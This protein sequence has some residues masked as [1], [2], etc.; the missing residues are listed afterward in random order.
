LANNRG[1]FLH[2]ILSSPCFA[3]GS[4]GREGL[5]ASVSEET[6]TRAWWPIEEILAPEQ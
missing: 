6:A 3:P 5:L 2:T 4:E 1:V